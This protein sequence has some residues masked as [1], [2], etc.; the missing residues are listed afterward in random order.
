MPAFLEMIHGIGGVIRGLSE[1]KP[2]QGKTVEQFTR[3]IVTKEFKEDN[4]S[5]TSHQKYLVKLKLN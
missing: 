1:L 4:V 2:I 5:T 3:V